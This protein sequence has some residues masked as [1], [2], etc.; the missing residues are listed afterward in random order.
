MTADRTSA[1]P[2]EM[3]SWPVTQLGCGETIPDN[4]W[5]VLTTVQT[6]EEIRVVIFNVTAFL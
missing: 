5:K 2:H 6:M 4:R 3:Q 1:G